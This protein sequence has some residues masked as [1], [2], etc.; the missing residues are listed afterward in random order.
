MRKC[1][2]QVAVALFLWF[3]G[4][5]YADTQGPVFGVS[6]LLMSFERVG[7]GD[8]LPAEAFN[9]EDT[10]VWLNEL[11]W[12]RALSG[13]ETNKIEGLEITARLVRSN[14]PS[15]EALED[16][17]PL[18]GDKVRAV[19]LHQLRVKV[20][21]PRG[22]KYEGV[23]FLGGNLKPIVNQSTSRYRAVVRSC[24][25]G[26]VQW[27]GEFQIRDIPT[28]GHHGFLDEL[29]DVFENFEWEKNDEH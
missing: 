19:L 2:F 6:P 18:C 11:T 20:G 29:N 24:R 26:E 14:T 7:E 16:L 8:P 22:W 21:V 1:H 25:T 15:A 27:R 12:S 4:L 9:G 23:P 3:T 28:R 13:K 10:A 17:K 5:C